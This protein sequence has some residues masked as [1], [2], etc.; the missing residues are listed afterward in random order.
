MQRKSRAL[1]LLALVGL[2]LLA[3]DLATLGASKPTVI[4]SSPPS[5]S[6]F[7]EGEDVAVQS[8]STDSTGISRVELLVDDTVVRIDPAPGTQV[9]Y[10][11]VQTW[12]AVA[13]AHKIGV[14]AYNKG[15]TA[16][17]P[18]LVSVSVLAGSAAATPT[19]LVLPSPTTASSSSSAAPKATSAP[20]PSCTNSASFVSDVS[21]PDGTVMAPNQTFN[22]VWRL[23][24]AGTCTWGSG[25][26]FVFVSG[27]QMT[28]TAAITV[29]ST[30]PGATVDLAVSIP[31]SST[32]ASP[33]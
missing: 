12:K 21:I 10:P 25:Y 16:S 20:V 5:G 32:F 23:K 15:G 14:R 19:A 30:V 7:H 27:K 29:P 8:T 9:S 1:F 24:N 3:C 2:I 4:V 18:A 11:L 22:K 33:P 26:Q 17:D 13:G 6:Q 28:T 31:S